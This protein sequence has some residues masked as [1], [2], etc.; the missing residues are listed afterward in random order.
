M[1]EIVRSIPIAR[2]PGSVFALLSDPERFPQFFSGV[3]RWEPLDE[4][5]LGVGA[6]YLVLIRAASVQAGGI[7]RI[8]EWD[9]PRRLGWA[10]ESGVEQSGRFCVEPAPGGS[11]LRIELMYELPGVRAVAWLAERI[12]RRIVDRHAH[13]ALLA[14]RRVVEFEQAP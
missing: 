14:A 8:V 11:T 13:A 6:R 7:V 9:P 12:A 5:R 2:A 3:T 1:I 4:Q 10:S